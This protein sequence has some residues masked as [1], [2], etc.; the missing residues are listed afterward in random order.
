MAETMKQHA[1]VGAGCFRAGAQVQLE[2][3]KTIAIEQLKE[4]DAV[5]A[6]DERGAIHLAKVTKVHVHSE[7]QPILRVKFWRGEIHITPNHWVLNQYGNFT[8]I[9]TLTVHDALVDGMGH[10]RPII[11]MEH[12]GDEPVYNLTVEPH[13]TFICDGVRVHN[14]GHR[15]RYPVVQGAGG[16]KGGG[17]HTPVEDDDTLQSR[18]MLAVLDL[19]GEGEIGGLVDGAKSIYFDETPVQ[20]PDGSVNFEGFSWA[21]ATGTPIQQPI[22]GFSDVETPY[23]VL[24]R[25]RNDLSH[26][27]AITNPNVDQVRVIVTIPSL[28]QTDA[29]DGDIHGTS[30][31]IRFDIASVINGVQGPFMDVTGV[32][33]LRGKSRGKYQ[34]AYLLT[35]PKPAEQWVIR[36][37]RLT[38][39][40]KTALVTNETYFDTYVEIVNTRLAY[41]YSALVGVR[42]D[43]ANFNSV[44]NRSYLVDGL[45]IQVPANYDARTRTY[46]GVW[47]GDMKP[48]I[49]SNPA[50]VLYD[51]LTSARYGLGDH[52]KPEQIDKAG[53]YRIGRYCDELVPDGRGGMEPRFSVNTVINSQQEAFKVISDLTSVFRGM[54]YW[55]G[56]MVSFTQDAPTDPSMVF[57]Q[58]NVIDGMFNYTGS[59]RKDR[60]SVA[61]ITW[62]D[63]DEQYKQKIEYVENPALVEKYGIRKIDMVA[64]GC[65][66]RGQAA[67][68]GHWMLYTE[69]FESDIIEF[70]VGLDA[71]QVLPGEVIKIHDQYRAGKRMGGRL[72]AATTTSATLDAPVTLGSAS[73]LLSLRL[74][75]GSFADRTVNEEAGTHTVL[76]WTDPLPAEPLPNAIWLVAEQALEPV[77]ARVI[78]I[79]QGSTPQQFKIMAMEH[80]PAKFDAI[81]KGL[82]LEEPRTS[83]IDPNQVSAPTQFAVTEAQYQVAPSVI[84][85]KLLVSWSGQ[86]PSYELQWR[87]HGKYATNWQT[88]TT[89]SQSVE[90]ENVRNS[91]HEFA[92]VAVNGFGRRSAPQSLLYRVTG[93]TT[94]PGDVLNFKVTNRTSDLL[95][96]WDA[97]TDVGVSGYEVRVGP[98]WDGAAVITSKFNGT[99]IT[100]DQDQAGTYYYHIR[101]IDSYGNYSDNVTTAVLVLDPPAPVA[102]FD[103]VQSGRRLEF[104]WKAN[105]E[106]NIVGYEIREGA[107]WSSS[108]LVT[109]VNATTYTMPAGSAGD[110]TFWIKAIASPGIYSATPAFVQTAIAQAT[111]TNLVYSVDEKVSG[112]GGVRHFMSPLDSDLKMDLA[113]PRAEYIF[114]VNLGSRYRAQNTL[115]ASVDSIVG[116]TQT[117][118]SANF[119]WNSADA[120]RQWISNGSLRSVGA[121]FQIATYAGLQAG[122]IDGWRFNDALTSVTNINPTEAVGVSYGKG[123]YGNGLL[124]GDTTSVAWNVTTPSV[125]NTTFWIVPKEVVDGIYWRLMGDGISL[126]V[127]YS[128]RRGAFYLEDQALRRIDVPFAF[129]ADDR[130][131]IGVVQTG[132][133]RKLMVGKMGASTPV[134]AQAPF[135]EQGIYTRLQLY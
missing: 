49:S 60:H 87:R 65:T 25:V 29:D 130:L 13:H 73:P 68:A 40:S 2:G 123:R 5:L 19:I 125:F 133:I 18:A 17:G 27:V 24:V 132:L 34:R 81:E 71:A 116:D 51:L 86:E 3:G 36:M 98:S 84:G 111:N 76:T 56:G 53:L 26:S 129:A 121:R 42:L 92:L 96:T 63:P 126:K 106:T 74:P 90:L 43:S 46:S 31:S 95:L 89:T 4:G 69:Q 54:A 75:D 110:R 38:A 9:G 119:A 102:Q 33:S 80:N 15:A 93:K 14:G 112:W 62:N 58:A 118:S 109:Q 8:E 99:M 91:A 101:S 22:A 52:I 57:S 1:I 104:R 128:V 113:V 107:S 124:L 70:Q 47:Q 82:A 83:I 21:Q 88:I 39:D 108:Q 115:F 64:F 78:G 77:S 28:M 50:W 44:P 59:A 131:C 100:H 120:N 135:G 23:P 20:N 105:A 114:N 103:C 122:E 45:Y 32:L 37:V 134:A 94:A 7:P 127:G 79:G 97:V 10:L 117:W 61:L 6:F 11:S 72:A 30:V 67:R 12:V 66:S 55:Y 35:L 85:T 16:G 48:A 41:P